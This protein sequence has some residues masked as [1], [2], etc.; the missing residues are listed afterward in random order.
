MKQYRVFLSRD[1]YN[2][3]AATDKRNE[4]GWAES[5]GLDI[6]EP[7]LEFIEQNAKRAVNPDIEI[8]AS[9]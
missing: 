4:R 8:G 2:V 3:F 6:S 5:C 1:R 9:E 7:K